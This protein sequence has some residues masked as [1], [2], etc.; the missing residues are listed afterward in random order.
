ML[1]ANTPIVPTHF[2]EA[3]LPALNTLLITRGFSNKLK[4]QQEPRRYAISSSSSSPSARRLPFCPV[5]WFLTLHLTLTWRWDVLSFVRRMNNYA[6]R[7][8]PSCSERYSVSPVI[9][10]QLA[11]ATA[12]VIFCHWTSTVAPRHFSGFPPTLLVRLIHGTCLLNRVC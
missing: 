12:A 7:T 10:H 11:T 9:R 8:H 4:C 3:P 1:S 2:A 6:I 5:A